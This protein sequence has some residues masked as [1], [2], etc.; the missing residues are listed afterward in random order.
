MSS[1]RDVFWDTSWLWELSQKN[2]RAHW[3]CWSGFLRSRVR[4]SFSIPALNMHTVYWERRPQHD[5]EKS[6][7]ST[8]MHCFR[9]NNVKIGLPYT[10]RWDIV[11]KCLVNSYWPHFI[12]KWKT[13]LQTNAITSK[14][15]RMSSKRHFWPEACFSSH[16]PCWQQMWFHFNTDGI[17]DVRGNLKA[18]FGGNLLNQQKI[19]DSLVTTKFLIYS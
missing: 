17:D 8:G 14:A 6:F 15:E 18:P 12:M 13:Q 11:F 3:H 4:Q 5:Y 9:L 7:S 10:L 16:L 2:I 1:Q 19:Y